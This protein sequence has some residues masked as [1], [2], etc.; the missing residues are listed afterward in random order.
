MRELCRDS[1]YRPHGNG[2][3]RV[4]VAAEKAVT[5]PWACPDQWERSGEAAYITLP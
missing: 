3:Y 2:T 1:N 5:D 4:M